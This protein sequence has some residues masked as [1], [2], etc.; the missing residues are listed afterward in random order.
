MDY[1]SDSIT[2]IREVEKRFT[3]WS[4][5]MLRTGLVIMLL[6]TLIVQPAY[7]E[8]NEPSS[9]AAPLPAWNLQTVDGPRIFNSMTDRSLAFRPDGVPCAA[10]GGDGLYYACFNAVTNVWTSV[11]VDDSPGVGQYAALTYFVSP[12]T[13]STES[14]ISYYDAINGR[15][16]L[17]FT[18]G[19]AWQV[20]ITVPTPAPVYGAMASEAP[21]PEDAPIPE[22]TPTIEVTPTLAIT[23]TIE[24]TPT[25]AITPT[26]EETPAV[27]P[28]PAPVD[29]PT[30]ADDVDFQAEVEKAQMPWMSLLKQNEPAFDPNSKGVGKYTSIGVDLDGVYISYYDD[31]DDTT[32]GLY[33]RNI[34]LAHWNYVTWTFKL[35][36]DYHDQGRVG[37]YSSLK[38]DYNSNVHIAYFDEKYDD[39]KYAVWDR[40][41][42]WFVKTVDGNINPITNVGSMCSL[43]LYDPK[44]FGVRATPWISY[45]DFSHSNL[46]VAKLINLN[47]N[48]WD[49]EVVD[50]N[51][52]TGWWTSIA[53]ESVSKVHI[54][55]Y[56]A[57][58]GDLKYAMRKTDGSWTLQ[59]LR[60]GNGQQ[61]QFSSIGLNPNSLRPGI[62][63]YNAT[64]GRMEFTRY[65]TS[66]DW[67][68]T[69][70]DI[71]GHDVG[72]SSSLFLTGAGAPYISYLDITQGGLKYAYALES[73]FFKQFALQAPHNGL[74]SSIDL[75]NNLPG[76]A[77]YE[78]DHGN[79]A[80]GHYDG[81][82]W[83]WEYV[84]RSYDVG[85]YISMKI[86]PTG[87]PRMSYYD[88]TNQNLNYARWE[89]AG[90]RWITETLDYEGNVGKYTSLAL[91]SDNRAYIS[92]FDDQNDE[93]ELAYQVPIFGFWEYVT[94]DTG[95]VPNAKVGQYTSLSLDSANNPHISYYDETNSALKYA[96]WPGP[97][98][99]APGVPWVI[100]T[101]DSAG[102]VGRFTSLKVDPLT[103]WRHICYYDLSNGALKYA[104]FDTTIWEL[105]MV[106]AFGDVGYSCSIDLTAAGEPAI[107]YYDNSRGDL[108]IALSYPLPPLIF[109]LPRFLPIVLD[110]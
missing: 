36:D 87:S 94:V 57:S 79:V 42:G 96:Y 65:K 90:S 63:H 15:L 19:G 71:N 91:S 82:Q 22:V 77:S 59:N 33:S 26:I 40:G 58:N 98:L 32:L 14:F 55:Y 44:D 92:Y 64:F 56:N 9:P 68:T 3:R 86:D 100:S 49:R 109:S 1:E 50:S 21:A 78:S 24:V 43:G 31:R 108:R 20:P 53:V 80:Y 93:L 29:A 47:Q 101:L 102:D 2:H 81:T 74:Y 85:Q 99:P 37:L 7:S 67:D 10:Y 89:I 73:T 97:G 107:T 8:E 52:T 25:L 11:V 69:V 51:G 75:Y 28:T 84:D 30:P 76:I 48:R 17:A 16:K 6:A 34:S 72:M 41:D 106:D 4:K 46:K 12:L 104:R 61:G 70:V 39:L 62:L 54:S 13:L 60:P 83:L 18:A 5:R 105:Q 88:A 38:V 35:V 27:E 110:P 66:I 45:L 103:N 95:G 23:P